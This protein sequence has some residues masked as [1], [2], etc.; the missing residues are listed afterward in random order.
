M[1]GVFLHG[2]LTM[3]VSHMETHLES[4]LQKIGFLAI[5]LGS[6]TL[7]NITPLVLSPRKYVH[8]PGLAP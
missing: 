7:P 3:S 2:L 8:N 4:T 1:M 5:V 6:E